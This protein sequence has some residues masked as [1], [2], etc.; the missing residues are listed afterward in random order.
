VNGYIA[1]FHPFREPL[2]PGT[3]DDCHRLCGG[4]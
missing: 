2:A 4:N 1:T 3:C